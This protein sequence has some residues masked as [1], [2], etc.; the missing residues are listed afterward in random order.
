MSGL[1]SLPERCQSSRQLSR[2]RIRNAQTRVWELHNV[3]TAM[4]AALPDRIGC[5]NVVDWRCAFEGLVRD[6]ASLHLALEPDG[7]L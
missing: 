5:A 2:D 7:V 6:L 3:L 1:T 4:S